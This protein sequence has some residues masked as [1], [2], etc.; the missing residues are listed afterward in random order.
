MIY[1]LLQTSTEINESP[2]KL[3]SGNQYQHKNKNL[4]TQQQKLSQKRDITQQ[5]CC[6]WLPI[7]NLTC[8]LQWYS[9]LQTSDEINASL[10]NLLNRNQYL[11]PTTKTKSKKGHNSAKIWWM[12][13]SIEQPVFYNDKPAFEWNQCISSKVIEWKRK[14]WWQQ[15]RGKNDP[16]VS[17]MLCRQH[18]IN[19]NA[20][21]SFRLYQR[22]RQCSTKPHQLS[23]L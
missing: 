13:T 18:K 11:N 5:K 3:L 7:S 22:F 23:W 2:Q 10:Q 8:I 15:R 6:G 21:D 19:K 20:V 4:S 17:I 1:I 12:I 14:V 16:Y 9:L